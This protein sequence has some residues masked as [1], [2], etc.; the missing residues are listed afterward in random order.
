MTDDDAS[1]QEQ[2]PEPGFPYR[3]AEPPADHYQVLGLGRDA[4]R[5]EIADAYDRQAAELQPDPNAPPTDPERLR[6]LDDA[7]DTLDDPARRAEYDRGLGVQHPEGFSY[8]ASRGEPILDRLPIDKR[9]L[10]A[11]ALLTAGAIALIAAIVVGILE[12]GGDNG[13]SG[14]PAACIPTG[15]ELNEGSQVRYVDTQAGSGPEAQSGQQLTV[16]Y[17]GRLADCSVFD[18]TSTRNQP[19]TFVVG[20]GQVI[21]GWDQGLLGMRQGGKRTLVI[22]PEL[23]YG[24][25]GAGKAIPP[26]ATL[27]FEVELLNISQPPPT[28][29]PQGAGPQTPP[30]VSGQPLTTA[31]GLQYIDIQEGTG[32]SPQTGQSVTVNYTG[33]L[34]SD[35][36]KFDSSLDRSDPF[37]FEIGTAKVIKGW[38]EGVATM[39]VGGKRRLII[40]PDLAYGEQG[41]GPIPGNATLIFDVE[42]LN[43]SGDTLTPSPS[44]SP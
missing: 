30:P 38:D 21:E 36:S 7:F 34:Q 31:S 33:W 17:T 14:A 19:F 32:V 15:Q 20:A 24:S 9:Y 43:V 28:P 8:D 27:T 5:R 3:P 2:R 29:T 12:I 4:T 42:L 18:S 35:S 41:V 22:P 1:T 40:P 13:G 37:T 25:Q 23:A 44:G 26:N 16:N 39:K 10:P 6:R 11:I